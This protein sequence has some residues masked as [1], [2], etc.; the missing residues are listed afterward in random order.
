MPMAYIQ[1]IEHK[2]ISRLAFCTLNLHKSSDPF[3]LL[4]SV[5][6]SGCNAFD[7]AAI[8]GDNE[9]Q[10]ILGSWMQQHRVVEDD[11]FLVTNSGH[12]DEFSLDPETLEQHLRSSL[13]RLQ[14]PCVDLYMLHRDDPSLSIEA[15]VDTINKLIS[16]GLCKKWGVSNWETDRLDA[17]ISYALKTQQDPPVCDSLHMSLAI[18]TRQVTP[19]TFFMDEKRSNWYTVSKGVSVFAR[20][21]LA[22]GFLTGSWGTAE[23]LTVLEQKRAAGE[24]VEP[25]S[26]EESWNQSNLEDAY[27]TRSNLDRRDRA[28]SLASTKGV[29]VGQIAVAY[30]LAKTVQPFV[31]VGTTDPAHWAFNVQAA[32]V[33][34]TEME[35]DWLEH[36]GA[37]KLSTST[38]HCLAV[39]E[40]ED[41]ELPSSKRAKTCHIPP[42]A[43]LHQALPMSNAVRDTVA[44]GRS[45]LLALAQGQDD[46]LMVLIG[47][48]SVHCPKAAIDYAKWLLPLARQHQNELVVLM[49]V[50]FEKPRTTVGW[51]GLISDP[52][53]NGSFNVGKG[54]KLARALL[55]DCAEMGLLS[56][57][58]FLAPNTCDYISD[59]VSYG[60]I[61][62]RTTES[63]CHREMA[64]NLGMPVG[65]KNGTSGDI[66]VAADAIIAAK[67]SNTFLASDMEGKPAVMV[68]DG[69]PGAHLILRGGKSG[70]NFDAASVA[71]AYTKLKESSRIVVDCSHGNSNKK[72]KNQPLVASDIA[73][74][75]AAGNRSIMGVMVESHLVE[76]N[77]SLNPGKTDPTSLTYGQSVTDACVGL[78][79]SENL[80]RELAEAV[81]SR[82]RV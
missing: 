33:G 2:L 76:G 59:L 22:M 17:A 69:N 51:K 36:G 27:L 38:F 44:A 40:E 23:Q 37:N 34:L 11:I 10:K 82:R 47:P 8:D 71:D 74:Q 48:C 15:I 12:G 41:I 16:L 79:D 60:A 67:A 61:G 5:Y 14:V 62:A 49:R 53:L 55:L 3:A 4:D 39:Q 81:Q 64:S 63:Q 6:G 78:E 77:Q 68:S 18:P 32:S 75:I 45:S 19:A 43:V 72:H 30:L 42:P 52:D 80:L 58:E 9:S 1:G 21:S 70:T 29:S 7:C 50:Y 73:Q 25:T 46:R 28:E 54:L 57:T 24:I 20:E 66:Q 56:G 31:L 26:R 13:E 65:F 35:V